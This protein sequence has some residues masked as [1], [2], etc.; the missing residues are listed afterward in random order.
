MLYAMIERARPD[1][2]TEADAPG[3]VDMAA[4]FCRVHRRNASRVNS[5]IGVKRLPLPA[6]TSDIGRHRS[7]P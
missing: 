4:T 6:L 7:R 2:G 3:K 1:L 5:P